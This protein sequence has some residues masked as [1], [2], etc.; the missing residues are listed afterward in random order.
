MVDQRVRQRAGRSEH[1]MVGPT[2]KQKVAHL[3]PQM[4][5]QKADQTALRWDLLTAADL[6]DQMV[7]QMAAHLVAHLVGQ[8][9]D[10]KDLL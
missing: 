3:D 10:R 8:T 7:S 5:V 6:A 2:V 1:L 9:V 4:A